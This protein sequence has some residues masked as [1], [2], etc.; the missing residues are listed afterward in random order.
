MSPPTSE[1][2]ERYNRYFQK[3]SKLDRRF[4]SRNTFKA[5]DSEAGSRSPSLSNTLSKCNETCLKTGLKMPALRFIYTHKHRMHQKILHSNFSIQTSH[6]KE[7][8]ECSSSST[9]LSLEN[10]SQLTHR[11][12]Q[13]RSS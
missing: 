8:L 4:L 3:P 11:Y 5:S 12:C 13:L 2:E 6:M 7:L 10:C 1:M 9:F